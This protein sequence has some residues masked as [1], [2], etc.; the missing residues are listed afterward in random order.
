MHGVSVEPGFP[1]LLN[2]EASE[3]PGSEDI[4]HPSLSHMF[5]M[6]DTVSRG[7]PLRVE[8]AMRVGYQHRMLTRG[9]T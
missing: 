9:V 4:D 6:T 3:L 1:C 2:V 5:K 7:Q 8:C